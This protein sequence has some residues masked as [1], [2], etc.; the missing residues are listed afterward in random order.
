M[1][2]LRFVPR[3]SVCFLSLITASESVSVSVRHT[4][5]I[6]RDRG[7]RPTTALPEEAVQALLAELFS[8]VLLEI[9][10]QIQV[11]GRWY[12]YLT[13]VLDP[14]RLP[15]EYVAE[16]YGQRWRIEDAFNVVKRLLGL[17]YFYLDE[18]ESK[19]IATWNSGKTYVPADP[20]T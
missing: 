20:Q 17:A 10:P 19:I 11:G 8:Q 18:I 1:L 4:H 6:Q 2:L 15:A 5:A 3:K 13:N 7:K 9:L 14:Q 12:R 16:L